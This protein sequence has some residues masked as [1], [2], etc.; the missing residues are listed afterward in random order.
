MH[1]T[2]PRERKVVLWHSSLLLILT[3]NQAADI[4]LHIKEEDREDA[5]VANIR[6]AHQTVDPPHTPMHV[7]VNS[8]TAGQYQLEA[9]LLRSSFTIFPVAQG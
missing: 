9:T 4:F 2:F 3:L 1:G 7:P 6:M 8:F 5:S